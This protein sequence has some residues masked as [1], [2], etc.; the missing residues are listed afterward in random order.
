LLD[1]VRTVNT[2]RLTK[3]QGAVCPETLAS[4]LAAL[5]DMFAA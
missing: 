5:Q 2:L 3:R 4:S 1:Q